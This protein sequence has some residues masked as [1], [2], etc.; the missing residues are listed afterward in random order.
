MSRRWRLTPRRGRFLPVPA[1][2]AVAPPPAPW[3]PPTVAPGSRRSRA[4]LP[5][6]RGVLIA[7]PPATVVVVAPTHIYRI[8]RT[9]RLSLPGP[10]RGVFLV[11]AVVG[12]PPV[13]VPAV[14]TSRRP[15]AL[16]TIRRGRYWV[17]GSPVVSHVPRL[18]GTPRQPLAAPRRGQFLTVALVGAPP[19]G[20]ALWPP[21][22]LRGA[23]RPIAPIRRGRFLIMPLVGAP[24]PVMTRGQMASVTRTVATM[25]G[26]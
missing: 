23:R 15:W 19:P 8:R 26:V 25:R 14:L 2:Q 5:V 11:V 21:V 17:L 7:V 6:R 16:R 22:V 9:V 4:P 20:P 3:I 18:R 10:R 1:S 24:P 12:A 13:L